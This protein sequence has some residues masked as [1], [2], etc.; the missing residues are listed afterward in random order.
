MEVE[1]VG[2]GEGGRERDA[3]SPD[4]Q[5]QTPE[6]KAARKPTIGNYFRAESE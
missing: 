5:N 6:T 4:R 2:D 3:R 1:G